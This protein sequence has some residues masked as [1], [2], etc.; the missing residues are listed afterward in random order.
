MGNNESRERQIFID[1]V[2]HMLQK[3]GVKVKRDNL[4]QFFKFIQEVCPWFPEEG[5]INEKTWGK[6]GEELRTHY[7]LHGP[8]KI[9]HD[10]FSL[11]NLIR[12]ALDPEPEHSKGPVKGER[13][14]SDE[15]VTHKQLRAMLANCSAE[16]STSDEKTKLLAEQSHG[17]DDPLDPGGQAKLDDEAAHY[18]DNDDDPWGLAAMFSE[19]IKL[20]KAMRKPNLPTIDSPPRK[21]S[22]R[23]FSKYSSAPPPPPPHRGLRIPVP[24][25]K[26]S[27]NPWYFGRI[28]SQ[29]NGGDQNRSSNN[30][31]ARVC[32]CLS[33]ERRISFVDTR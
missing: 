20:E 11:W 2:K 1:V 23:S 26:S 17:D 6:V 15:V 27:I 21:P 28:S 4:Q 24:S 9:P 32:L 30:Q 29:E 25:E 19:T 13:R 22:E 14:G 12:D 31:G 10:T 33:P 18:R 8:E 3:R 16:E 7:S 5:T